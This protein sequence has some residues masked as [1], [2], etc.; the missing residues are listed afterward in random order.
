MIATR[1]KDEVANMRRA[2]KVVA[3]VLLE[4]AAHVKPGVTGLEL[5]RVAEEGI[6]RR[7]ATPAFLGYRGYPATLCASVNETVVH[8]IPNEKPLMAGDIVGLDLGAIVEGS[9]ADAAFTVGV[10]AISPKAQLL[11]KVARD[12]LYQAIPFARDGQR[13][14]DISS[15]VQTHVERNG[16][17][18]V[19]EFVGHG[20]GKALHEDPQI[21]NFG[22]PH[23]GPK[24]RAGMT[25][26]IEPMVNEGRPA[27]EMQKDGWTVV[28]ADRTLSAH[29]EHTILVTEAGPEILTPWDQ[30]AW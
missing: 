2:G 14:G 21:P 7:G 12:A 9:Y 17:S 28:T 23:S 30:G 22:M 26:C 18:V 24:L 27:V 10:G 5:D 19:R 29:F 8:G 4:L 6:R 11:T 20:I 16:F 25:I 15:S 1:H 13:V 3:D